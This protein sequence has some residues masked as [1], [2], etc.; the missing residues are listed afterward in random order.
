[1]S[2]NFGSNTFIYSK[3]GNKHIISKINHFRKGSGTT[4]V[5]TSGG[6]GEPLTPTANSYFT[7]TLLDDGTYS[8]K[9]KDVTNMPADVVLPSAYLGKKVTQIAENAFIDIETQ[10]TCTSIKRCYVPSSIT[11]IGNMAFAYCTNLEYVT[12]SEGLNIIGE[13]PFYSCGKLKGI[14]IPYSVI[15]I[16]SGLTYGCPQIKTIYCRNSGRPDGWADD[17]NYYNAEVIWGYSQDDFTF[18]EQTDGT[19]SVKAKD[20]SALPSEVFIP[21]FY[22]GKAV[23][24]IDNNA[25]QGAS[26]TK[27]VIPEG[28]TKIGECGFDNCK[29][30][31]DVTLPS[32]LTEIGGAAFRDCTLLTSIVIPISVTTMGVWAFLRDTSLTINCEATEQPSGWDANWNQGGCPVVWGYTS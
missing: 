19:Y 7:F 29:K 16:A 20:V 4:T 13:K 27:V 14:L 9:A 24:A 10:T 17:W 25:F 3:D 23:T 21:C 30:L 26:I 18:T 2:F 31:T 28:V 5:W 22:N 11:T 12:L 6:S 1:M 8:I 15:T 32:T